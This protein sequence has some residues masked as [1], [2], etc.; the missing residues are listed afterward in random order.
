MLKSKSPVTVAEF[1]NQHVLIGPL[2][3]SSIEVE[4]IDVET[5]PS[6]QMRD[7]ITN[8]KSKGVEVVYGKWLIDS[9]PTV[10][11][12]NVNSANARLEEWKDDLWEVGQIPMVDND[13][14]FD[15]AILFG[16]LVAWFLGE[17][18]HRLKESLMN[19][20]LTTTDL[21]MS[22][23]EPVESPS[24]VCWRKCG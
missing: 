11:L 9:S 12:F 10:V 20:S 4:V 17:L 22:D 15:Q 2:T 16:Y 5:I 6:T 19:G 8:M 3:Q 7:T 18:E 23:M 1:G 13:V 14:E 21:H 24:P